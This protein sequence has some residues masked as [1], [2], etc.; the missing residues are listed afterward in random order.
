MDFLGPLPGSN[1]Y[2]MILNVNDHFSKQVI[3]IPCQDTTSSEDLAQLFIDNVFANHSLPQKIISN[4]GS[5]F[6]SHFTQSL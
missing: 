3:I 4:R 1:G 6:M 2:N 5:T